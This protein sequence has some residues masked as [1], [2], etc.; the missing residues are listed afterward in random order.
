MEAEVEKSLKLEGSEEQKEFVT[1]SAAA[2]RKFQA[3][4][5]KLVAQT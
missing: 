4:L 2:M 1:K 5:L 3:F